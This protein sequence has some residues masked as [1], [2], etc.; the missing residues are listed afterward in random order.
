[1]IAIFKNLVIPGPAPASS[2]QES[3]TQRLSRTKAKA[4]GSGSRPLRGLVRND[5]IVSSHANVT[6]TEFTIV[7]ET[8]RVADNVNRTWKET[9]E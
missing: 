8:A 2:A 5:G 7:Q 6:A 4:L 9:V 3:G 1:V